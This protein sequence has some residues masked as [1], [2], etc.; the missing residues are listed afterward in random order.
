MYWCSP[1]SCTGILGQKREGQGKFISLALKRLDHA[2]F[3]GCCWAERAR[4]MEYRS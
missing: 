4:S 3:R 2:Y 1:R